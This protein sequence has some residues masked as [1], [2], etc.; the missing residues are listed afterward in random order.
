MKKVLF[1]IA[2]AMTMMLL[3]S[4]CN[5]CCETCG[6]YDAQPQNQQN[7]VP[8]PQEKIVGFDQF[9]G[10]VKDCPTSDMV[11]VYGMNQNLLGTYKVDKISL[12]KTLQGHIY[13]PN[14]VARVTVASPYVQ[15]IDYY[16]SAVGQKRNLNDYKII[17]VY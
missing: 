13:Y 12:L 14:L 17:K 8:A 15:M 4:S 16:G 11:D 7:Q 2:A 9:E 10:V 1:S 5:K 6:C 3:T